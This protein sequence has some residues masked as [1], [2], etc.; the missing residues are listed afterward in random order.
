MKIVRT[1][2]NDILYYPRLYNTVDRGLESYTMWSLVPIA[3]YDK[4]GNHK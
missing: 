4:R 2:Y 3:I 1:E